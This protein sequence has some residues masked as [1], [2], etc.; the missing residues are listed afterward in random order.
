MITFLLGLVI[1]ES[2]NSYHWSFVQNMTRNE[3]MRE[4]EWMIEGR[5]FLEAF[6]F[7]PY[8]TPLQHTVVLSQRLMGSA[9]VNKIRYILWLTLVVC[10]I[11]PSHSICLTVNKKISSDIWAILKTWWEKYK[12][13]KRTRRESAWKQWLR[14]VLTLAAMLD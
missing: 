12:F 9:I 13:L 14:S 4:P 10:R 3:Q 6:C 2:F 8:S 1:I 7:A 5:S 11:T